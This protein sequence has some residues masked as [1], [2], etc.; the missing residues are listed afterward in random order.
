MQLNHSSDE[1]REPL[2]KRKAGRSEWNMGLGYKKKNGA[3]EAA[4]VI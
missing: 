4:I 2:V 1:S 3:A